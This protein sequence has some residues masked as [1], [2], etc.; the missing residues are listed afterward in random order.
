[1]DC[2]RSTLAGTIET[3]M[4]SDGAEV[5]ALPRDIDWLEVRA[6]VVGDVDADWLRARFAGKLLYSLR[7]TAE[8]G[9]GAASTGERRARLVRAA[10][11]Y[12]LVELEGDRDLVPE[13]LNAIGPDGRV[14]SWHGPAQ[15]LRALEARFLRI[16]QVPARL[17]RLVSAVERNGDELA[18]LRL[19]EDLRRADTIAY[20]AGHVGF[21]T[22]LLAPHV[23]CPI[24]FGGI[25][26][27]D[28]DGREPSV[29]RLL[30][31]YGLPQLSPPKEL[32][33]IAGTR[34]Y[35][36]RSPYLHN[37][38]YRSLGI[39]AL[40]VPLPIASFDDFWSRVVEADELRR[41]GLSL[42][43]LTIAS[44]YKEE[45]LK[46]AS[47]ISPMAQRAESTNVLVRC[48][49]GW[50][51]DTTDPEGVLPLL[52]E[53]RIGVDRRRA[54]VV[55][56]GGSGR[57]V[58]ASLQFA[59]ADVTLVNRG[60]ERGRRAVQLL[61]MNF[62][63]LSDFSVG[64]YSLIVNATPVGTAPGEMPFDVGRLDEQAIVVDHVYNGH[65]TP[66][67]VATRAMGRV[68]IEGREILVAQVRRQFQRMVGREMPV[69]SIPGLAGAEVYET[70]GQS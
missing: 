57:A 65:P 52:Q 8:G 18:S 46:R 40:F 49:S 55:G 26:P 15:E 61:G 9:R 17:Y 53:R 2:V 39:P 70:A 44:P 51:A 66:L 21:W 13:V 6:D 32:F 62:V 4:S 34:A 12:D 20:A 36:S 24:V 1:M 27:A 59:G 67:M 5:R 47:A 68:A 69:I 42:N 29:F 64:G 31:D 38:A 56:C 23:G 7:S 3:P 41:L 28:G 48:A 43:G 60:I 54:A 33:G 63:P 16:S 22:R 45:A 30:N 58:A 25:D 19:L 37:A 11:Q 35:H 10:R 50:N 14:L